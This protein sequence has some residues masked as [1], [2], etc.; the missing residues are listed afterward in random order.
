MLTK[1]QTD[2]LK[3]IESRISE[4]NNPPTVQEISTVRGLKTKAI[5][6]MLKILE[7]KGAIKRKPLVARSIVIVE[8]EGGR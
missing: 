1:K 3:C 8:Q 7:R 4:H 5:K 2:L 6:D